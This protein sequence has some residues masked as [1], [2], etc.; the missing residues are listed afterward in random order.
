MKS[1]S[2]ITIEE[3]GE[4]YAVSRSTVYRLIESKAIQLVKIGRAS[5]IKLADA[6]R[7]A[8]SLPGYANE[9]DD[10]A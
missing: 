7:W 4:R 9:L 6:E 10:A 2:L 3:F 8:R 1:P 5:R